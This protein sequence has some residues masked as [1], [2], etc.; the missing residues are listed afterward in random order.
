M[1]LYRV[2]PGIILFR[3][4]LLI[5]FCLLYS[6]ILRFQTYKE[7]DSEALKYDVHF[8]I[9]KYSTQVLS[10]ALNFIS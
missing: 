1:L 10:N 6:V 4:F 8:W 2:L 3:Q 5:V 7:D 9:G